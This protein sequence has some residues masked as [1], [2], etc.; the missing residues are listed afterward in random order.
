MLAPRADGVKCLYF[1]VSFISIE[2]CV[3]ICREWQ[4]EK[5][6]KKIVCNFA[7]KSL[8]PPLM[9][10]FRK[11]KSIIQMWIL[12][13]LHCQSPAFQLNLHQTKKNLGNTFEYFESR[14]KNSV[15]LHV[16][17]F[18]LEN[19]HGH[20]KTRLGKSKKPFSILISRWFYTNEKKINDLITINVKNDEQ[21]E[22]VHF[23][24]R[25]I[26]HSK[27]AEMARSFWYK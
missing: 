3:W 14:A 10:K 25:T 1:D 16:Y 13:F 6:G 2:A 27:W 11:C 26:N 8:S 4:D 22:S 17:R 23:V 12:N 9:E 19:C 7:L 24:H 5:K 15:S 20:T 18:F 21:K